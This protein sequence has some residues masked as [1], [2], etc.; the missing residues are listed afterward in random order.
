M[1]TRSGSVVGGARSAAAWRGG[2]R[3]GWRSGASG[4]AAA[5]RPAEGERLADGFV[6]DGTQV[7]SE[8]V[9]HHARG[10][11]SAGAGPRQ[12]RR[13]QQPTGNP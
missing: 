1:R 10:L 5:H 9:E 3:A 4:L 13:R 2:V 6:A 11:V 12:A 7:V 8:Q